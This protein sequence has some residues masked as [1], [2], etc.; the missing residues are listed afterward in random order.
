MRCISCILSNEDALR[1]LRAA[2]GR[3]VRALAETCP[4]YLVLSIE[5]QMPGV[6][7]EEAKY[8]FT[9]PLRERW[10]QEALWGGLGDGSLCVVST[11]HCPFRFADQKELG[12]GGFSEDSEWW[13]GD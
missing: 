4:Q 11:D 13:A 2:Q 7:W 3:G 1:E 6:S 12:A 9:P 8:V 5:E 10:N